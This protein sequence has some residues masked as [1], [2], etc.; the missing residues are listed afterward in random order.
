[1]FG[2]IKGV[3]LYQTNVGRLDRSIDRYIDNNIN[4]RI[5]RKMYI[6]IYGKIDRYIC[7]WIDIHITCLC[8]YRHNTAFLYREILDIWDN[9]LYIQIDRYIYRPI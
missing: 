2:I 8:E 7:R 3:V 9:S 4:I 5:D 6:Y 1:M